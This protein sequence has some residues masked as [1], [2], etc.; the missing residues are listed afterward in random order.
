MDDHALPDHL[1]Q[2]V[3]PD[4]VGQ[5]GRPVEDLG[6]T[7]D[8]RHRMT[9]NDVLQDNADL[10]ERAGQLLAALP[11]RTLLVTATPGVGVPMSGGTSI[12]FVCSASSGGLLKS[13]NATGVTPAAVF[14][15]EVVVLLL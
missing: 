15:V 14:G 3:V 7:P 5:L 8:V 6:V 9:A 11:I 10:M 12:S 2:G 1:V 4:A 13:G